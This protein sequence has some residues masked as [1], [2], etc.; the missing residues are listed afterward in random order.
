MGARTMTTTRRN[1]KSF[2]LG[3]AI[4]LSV[5]AIAATVYSYFPPPGITYT[6]AG[7]MALGTPT[8]GVQGANTLNAAGVFVNGV[9]VSTGSGGTPG[10]ADT[11]V[12]F[13]NAGAFGGSS[14]FLYTATTH[15]LTLNPPS[16]SSIAFTM[17]GATGADILKLLSAGG[18]SSQTDIEI[19]RSGSTINT[20]GAGPN[21]LLND[22]G[23]GTQSMLQQSG[24]Q[25]E[26]WQ[27]NGTWSQAWFVDAA[28][29]LHEN[30]GVIV[31][32]TT[33][34]TTVNA[35]SATTPY[36]YNG[37]TVMAF[38]LDNTSEFQT[39]VGNLVAVGANPAGITSFIS[40]CVGT[41]SCGSGGAGMS[42][43]ENTAVGWSALA[44]M[45]TG[46]NNAS[47]GAGALWH[48]TT[49]S[50]NVAF[51]A[52]GSRNPIGNTNSV[53]VGASAD[54]NMILSQGVAVGAFA[55]S[56][57]SGNTVGGA[58][59]L[60]NDTAVGFQSQQ[61]SPTSTGFQ[62]T[63]VGSGA[64]SSTSL[65]TAHDASLVGYLAGGVI[66]TA[67]GA[68]GL[69]SEALFAL[70]TGNNNTG[71]GWNALA[72]ITT[73]ANNTGFG[74]GAFQFST[75]GAGNT[76][77]GS[78]A[79]QQ[80]LSGSN[81]VYIGLSAGGNSTADTT[82]IG[83]GAFALAGQTSSTGN[84]NIGIGFN[85][86][87]NGTRTSGALN[88]ALGD[89]ALQ[90]MTTASNNVVAGWHAA[91][92][93]TAGN[94]NVIIGQNVATTTFTN[95]NGNILIGTSSATDT[96]VAGTSNE[97]NLDGL[98]F[99]NANSIAAPAVTACGTGPA[100]DAHANNK[101]GTV[102]VGTVAAA[103]CT[104]T[105]A[106]TGYNTWNHCR[107]TSQSTI[108]SFAYSYTLTVLTVTGTS[109]VGDKFDYDC[110]GY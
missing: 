34:S 82:S 61:G 38:P 32:G 59:P 21:I 35:T 65:T 31:T 10:G 16:A 23:N 30:A 80:N 94:N 76:A 93:L 57:G 81:S 44:N 73:T 70:T 99:L 106:G 18:A 26:L 87:G 52:D 85:V 6:P 66:T 47:L 5:P 54:K 27:S 24:G 79:G 51:G 46:A 98:F 2:A 86:M 72:S 43:V 4:A 20:Q 29:K 19:Q 109:L 78:G 7:G 42:G 41:H 74:A 49:G 63:T 102:T 55:L 84:E 110:D 48:E 22:T 39:W 64:M 68:T 3:L 95:G 107:V 91:M 75:S 45:T 62:N 71:A 83:I 89:R 77:M 28:L 88:L 96:P 90:A 11:Q 1:L 103:S 8:G 40:T 92:I 100:I 105:F 101:S 56:G 50:G 37:N 33:T 60:N 9:A 36:Q 25:T 58:G 15:R 104:V 69:G 67:L 108:A 14:N 12:Q 97:I 53:A 17:S 13:N